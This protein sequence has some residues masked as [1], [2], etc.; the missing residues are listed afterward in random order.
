MSVVAASYAGGPADRLATFAR[1]GVLESADVHVALRLG[2]LAQETSEDVLL[3]VALTVRA[4]R[5]GS[6]CLDLPEAAEALRVDEADEDT[7]I[8][9]EALDVPPPDSWAASLAA[10][11]LVATDLAGGP[12]RPLRLVGHLLY[13]DRYWREES[14]IADCVDERRSRAPVALDVVRLGD[15][16][17][18]LFPDPEPDRQRLAVAVAA[19]RWVTV[20]AGGPGTGKTTTVAKLLVTLQD[21]A[22]GSRLR[23]ALAAPTGKAAARLEEA[24][25]RAADGLQAPDRAVLDG[26]AA[27]TLHRLLGWAGGGARFRHDRDNP[28]PYDVIVVDEAS[29]VPLTMMARLVEALRDSCRL[30]LVGDPDQLASV[31]AGAVLGDLVRRPAPAE[32][33]ELELA[34]AAPAEASDLPA[35]VAREAVVTLTRV[36]RTALAEGETPTDIDALARAINAQ[37]ADEVIRILREG[38]GVELVAPEDLDGVRDDVVGAGTSLLEHATAGRALEAVRALDQHRVLCAHRRGPYGVATWGRE[39]EDWLREALPSYATDGLWYVGRP[40]LVT[41]N[42]P[43]LGVYNGDTG[44][45]VLRDGRPRAVF[46]KGGDTL[47][48][49]VSRLSDVTTVH[50]M[51]VH[52]SQG[53]E[54]SAVTLVLPEHTSPLLSKELFYTAVTRARRAVRVVGTEESVRAA[55]NRRVQR[56]SGLALVGARR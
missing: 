5:H 4:V 46:G 45:V 32:T 3:G 26:L 10:S 19:H 9:L 31:E 33:T 34:T 8:L 41:S 30:V 48:F 1:A 28:L 40:L 36:H 38:A 39:V 50:A 7:R 44:V 15:T 54:F 42:D 14:L 25:R 21:Q 49:A 29:M 6:V 53:S 55:V 27:T 51:S 24:V 22:G 17:G 23:V 47:E 13:L 11:P 37:R 20:L 12:T 18:R 2:E 43:G 56:A 16:L 52:K 35:E